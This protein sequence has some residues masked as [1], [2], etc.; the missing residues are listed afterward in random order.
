[1]KKSGLQIIF[2]I[3]IFF[4]IHLGLSVYFRILS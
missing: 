4:A 3:R 2:K 1:M